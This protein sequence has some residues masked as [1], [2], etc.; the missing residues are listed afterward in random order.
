LDR[1]LGGPQSL[2]GRGIYGEEEWTGEEAD[3]ACF[4]VL[5]EHSPGV[6]EENNSTPET[7]YL[8]SYPRFQP[9]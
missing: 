3:I 6:T 1:S 5:P 8:M 7:G 4:K 2:S 9:E